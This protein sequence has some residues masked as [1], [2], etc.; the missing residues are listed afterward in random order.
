ME[1]EA[2]TPEEALDECDADDNQVVAFHG[3][4]S[5]QRTAMIQIQ[6]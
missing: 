6:V 4:N 3:T 2:P 1:G 5:S